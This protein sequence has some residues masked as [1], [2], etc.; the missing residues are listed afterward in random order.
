VSFGNSKGSLKMGKLKEA[1]LECFRAM[2][3]HP[4]VQDVRYQVLNV[5]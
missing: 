5:R 4:G 1:S 3:Q 2:K